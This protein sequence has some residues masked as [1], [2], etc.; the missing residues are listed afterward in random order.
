MLRTLSSRRDRFERRLPK[1][2][3]SRRTV[4]CRRKQASQIS[5]DRLIFIELIA[6]AMENLVLTRLHFV[7]LALQL[8]NAGS[9]ACGI[10]DPR[11]QD[12]A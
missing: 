2:L 8:D 4:D 1:G 11:V 3:A 12:I 5:A 9:E 10:E 7:P 6:R